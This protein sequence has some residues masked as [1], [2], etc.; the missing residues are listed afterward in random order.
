MITNRLNIVATCAFLAILI[1]PKAFAKETITWVTPDWSPYFIVKGTGKGT[2][3][4]DVFLRFFEKNLPD[5]NHKNSV[6]TMTRYYLSAKENKDICFCDMLKT[7]E[8]ESILYYSKPIVLA[9]A[10]RIYIKPGGKIN[11]G[12]STVTSL[13][14]LMS[15]YQLNGIFEKNRSYGTKLDALIEK[16]SPNPNIQVAQ[17]TP[18]R[19]YQLL[20]DQ[21]ADYI[22]EYPFALGTTQKRLKSNVDLIPLKISEQVPYTIAYVTCAKTP[23]GLKVINSINEVLDKKRDSDEYRKLFMLP[24]RVMSKNGKLEYEELWDIFQKMD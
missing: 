21:R 22:V 2:G 18:E 15:D 19:L 23:T 7:P 1:A 5:Y 16:Y 11:Q 3:Y 10:L 14:E 24:T 4:S 12:T 17:V 8:R 6:M 20:E 9:A 13:E